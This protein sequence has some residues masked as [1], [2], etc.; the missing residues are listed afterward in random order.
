MASGGF[1]TWRGWPGRPNVSPI[2]SMSTRMHRKP[3]PAKCRASST[4]FRPAPV[5]SRA[6]ADRNTTVGDT[7]PGSV[8][9]SVT[10]PNSPLGPSQH[11]VLGDRPAVCITRHLG[12]GH[13]LH[14]DGT[15]RGV[16]CS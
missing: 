5:W 12:L 6:P 16:E 7:G 15:P 2:P 13:R 11:R 3:W 10:M 14:L 9:G 1:G 4:H 8:P